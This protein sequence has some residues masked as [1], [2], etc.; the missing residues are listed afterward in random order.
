[1]GC[2]NRIETE[3]KRQAA[4]QS[5]LSRNPKAFCNK[6]QQKPVGVDNTHSVGCNC[7]KSACLK[8]YCECFQL[9]MTCGGRCKCV[10]CLNFDGSEDLAIAR[11]K[12]GRSGHVRVVPTPR[13][14]LS[15]PE[16]TVKVLSV[17]DKER[18]T[19][20]D[21]NPS[22]G[23]EGDEDDKPVSVSQS[24]EQVPRSLLCLLPDAV[25]KRSSSISAAPHRFSAPLMIDD[26]VATCSKF[27][28]SVEQ[29]GVK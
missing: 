3:D 15:A 7:K 25:S 4:I 19:K 10:S 2:L 6:V 17:L 28:A 13:L 26:P 27:E 18:T 8:K 9:G 21:N 16:S 24:K 11:H 23:E 20:E 5:T 1:M 14:S 12:V 29:E 22:V